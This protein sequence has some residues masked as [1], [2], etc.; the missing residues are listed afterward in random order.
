M[1]HLALIFFPTKGFCFPLM[2]IVK[3]KKKIT[4]LLSFHPWE[5]LEAK[6]KISLLAERDSYSLG[7]NK[8]RTL[9]HCSSE[10]SVGLPR[11]FVANM[12]FL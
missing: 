10:G 4:R 11:D 5:Q 8:I 3:L 7:K 2:H 9:Y 6:P 1:E 12:R